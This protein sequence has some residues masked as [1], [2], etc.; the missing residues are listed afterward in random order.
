M[1]RSAGRG[2][3]RAR[4]DRRACGNL[5][6][7]FQPGWHPAGRAS[8]PAPPS[9]YF[10]A[11]GLLSTEVAPSTVVSVAVRLAMPPASP[12]GTS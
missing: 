9:A 10:S 3:A 2:R 5:D 1:Y 7:A 8:S 11:T 6:P 12:A 4:P